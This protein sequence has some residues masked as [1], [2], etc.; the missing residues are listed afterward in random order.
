M[1]ADEFEAI[2]ETIR[3]RSYDDR[4]LIPECFNHALEALRE[5]ACPLAECCCGTTPMTYDGPLPE[6]PEHG[7][8]Q[9]LAEQALRRMVLRAEGGVPFD[10]PPHTEEHL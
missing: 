1:K 9:Y 4:P 5:I 6:C 2:T 10:E 7:S 8:P 3:R